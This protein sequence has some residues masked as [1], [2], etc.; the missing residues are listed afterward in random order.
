VRLFG[1]LHLIS[2]TNLYTASRRLDRH[3]LITRCA[4]GKLIARPAEPPIPGSR[5]LTLLGLAGLARF[6]Q[7]RFHDYIQTIIQTEQSP[8]ALSL[9]NQ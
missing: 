1:Y 6:G 4:E 2:V 3:A 8:A 7:I 9:E 5:G